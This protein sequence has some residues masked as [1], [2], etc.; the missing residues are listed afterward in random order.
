[1]LPI[2]GCSPGWTGSAS[3]T[4]CYIAVSAYKDMNG[5]KRYCFDEYNATVAAPKT[6]T[7]NSFISKL[8][9]LTLLTFW[10]IIMEIPDELNALLAAM[11]LT[12]KEPAWKFSTSTDQV[13]VQLTWTKAKEQEAP[14]CKLKPALKSKPPSTRRRDA[15]RYDHWMANKTAVAP[16][17]PI[18]QTTIT[19]TE[20][21]DS[22]VGHVLTPTN[23]D[24]RIG[25]YGNTYQ[26]VW[27][28]YD[29]NDVN[30]TVFS[31]SPFCRDYSTIEDC[32]TMQH[33]GKWKVESCSTGRGFVCQKRLN[34][35][36]HCSPLGF[37]QH[38]YQDICYK[39]LGSEY[40]DDALNACEAE[41]L[42]ILMPK[43]E[44]E[45]VFMKWYIL[46]YINDNV[47][48][49]LTDIDQEGTFV[50]NKGIDTGF[51][52]SGYGDPNNACGD[53]HCVRYDSISSYNWN[54]WTC[55][56]RSTVVCQT[57]GTSLQPAVVETTA[58]SIISTVDFTT[59]CPCAC[60]VFN[61]TDEY[62]AKYI[63]K[64][65]KELKVDSETLSST[66][67]SKTCAED[68]RQSAKNI[69]MLGVA[70]LAFGFTLILF[71][72][73]LSFFQKHFSSKIDRR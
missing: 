42:D 53:Q 10:T 22:V 73:I 57:L 47:W 69:G 71:M 7:E 1:M 52:G 60:D 62:I 64:L 48:V 66:I 14:S 44:E 33:D 8:K 37:F 72:D 56:L 45:H 16:A 4:S 40:Y 23:G 41:G 19:Q 59:Y 13:T 15:K 39:K 28:Y 43:T 50:W 38:P 29:G 2:P 26:N 58:L 18:Q 55:N 25:I 9:S 61:I 46:E 32:I 35:M 67:R 63:K 27:E 5:A 68:P 70:V 30:L 54:D 49:G 12:G 51:K 17:A 21:R 3:L 11:K 34:F 36:D 24:I 20:A 31:S 6:E 65:Q